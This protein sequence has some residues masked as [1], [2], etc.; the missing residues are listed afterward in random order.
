MLEVNGEK[1]YKGSAKREPNPLSSLSAEYRKRLFVAAAS[2]G[3]VA[4][5]PHVAFLPNHN[6]APSVTLSRW[7]ASEADRP[8]SASLDVREGRHWHGRA[9]PEQAVRP[10]LDPKMYGEVRC[11]RTPSRPVPS[12]RRAGEGFDALSLRR[13]RE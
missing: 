2:D 12:C 9:R 10:G 4:I 5:L 7:R 11:R 13:M 3:D 8:M 1:T 6:T